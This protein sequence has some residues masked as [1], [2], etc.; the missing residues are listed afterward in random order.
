[1]PDDDRLFIPAGKITAAL[2]R[3][4]A[5]RPFLAR[6]ARRALKGQPM[7]NSFTAGKIDYVAQQELNILLR[8]VTVRS[9]EGNV[10]G[11]M[12]VRLAEP[13]VWLPVAKALGIEA[14]ESAE[15]PRAMFARLEWS[16]PGK[17]G[18]LRALEHEQ[19]VSKYLKSGERCR[20]WTKL[21][22]LAVEV[23]SLPTSQVLTLSQL[24]S[25]AFNDSKV[26]R[27]GALRRQ[28]CLILAAFSGMLPEDERGVFG[29]FGIVENPYTSSVTVFAPFAF[30]DRDGV[31]FDFPARMFAA[32]LACQLP[33]ETVGHMTRVE[34]RGAEKKVV[35]SENA[36]PLVAFVEK[37]IPCVYTEGY[38]NTAVLRLLELISSCGVTA[39]HWG[40]A[41][42]DGLL[43]AHA[44]ST[45]ISVTQTMALQIINMPGAL[46]GIP[47]TSEQ[48]NRIER[49]IDTRPMS[50][51]TGPLRQLLA[52]D[53]WYEQEAFPL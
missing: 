41:D 18:V 25:S 31:V 43:I 48:R 51:Y 6:L 39:S 49:F 53:C 17:M 40:D 23:E 42:L 35:T 11:K 50:E 52:R 34:W 9:A 28:L 20:E 27:S 13:E 38:P 22:N 1:M 24:G 15:T 45:K 30:C 36:A 7:P 46:K 32:G 5:L 14:N 19:E 10:H 2:N 8:T 29:S 33:L 37:R 16:H 3:A 12:P 21:F 44:V 47:L 26:L 4:P